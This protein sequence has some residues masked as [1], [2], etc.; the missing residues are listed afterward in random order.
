MAFAHST[1]ALVLQHNSAGADVP[2]QVG[3]LERAFAELEATGSATSYTYSNCGGTGRGNEIVSAC[4]SC[5]M[6]PAMPRSPEENTAAG[7]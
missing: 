4:A 3:A 2:D 5:G 1:N 7:E 6:E